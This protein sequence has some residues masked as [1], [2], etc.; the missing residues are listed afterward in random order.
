MKATNIIEALF[1]QSELRTIWIFHYAVYISL[2]LIAA[3]KVQEPLPPPST[4]NL[5]SL[6]DVAGLLTV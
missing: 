6:E 4:V 2:T 5:K 3:S 1:L